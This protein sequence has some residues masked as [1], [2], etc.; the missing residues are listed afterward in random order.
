[1]VIHFNRKELHRI[2][3]DAVLNGTSVNVTIDNGIPKTIIRIHPSGSMILYGIENQD[4]A[5]FTLCISVDNQS[6]KGKRIIEELIKNDTLKAFKIMTDKRS[7]IYVCDYKTDIDS[8]I[9]KISEVQDRLKSFLPVSR[10][11]N[12]L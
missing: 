7:N 11:G 3:A 4:E 10:A 5:G 8:I 12:Y 9:N 6:K 2:L 1:M